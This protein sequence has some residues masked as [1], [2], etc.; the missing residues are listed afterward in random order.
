MMSLQQEEVEVPLQFKS[1][2]SSFDRFYVKL[3]DDYNLLKFFQLYEFI[4]LLTNLRIEGQVETDKAYLHELDKARFSVFVDNKILKNH[5]IYEFTAENEE[6]SNIFKDY[7]LELFDSLIKCSVD[8]YKTKNPG[9]KVK[10]GQISTVKKL[11]LIS[12]GLLYCYSNNKSKVNFLFN[13]F[14]SE[15]GN[16]VLNEDLEDFLFFL[17]IIPASCSLWVIKNLGDKYE[18]IGP[19]SESDFEN[20]RNNFEVKDVL[21]LRGIFIRDFFKG[22]TRLTREAFD[23]RFE[24]ADG[25]FGWIFNTNG[26]RRFLEVN[27]DN[28]PQPQA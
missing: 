26:I 24:I 6:R 2:T 13:L 22:E 15:D 20:T 10:K 14:L 1:Y 23:K 7:M 4:L 18:K 17:F 25:D 28:D 21:R 19:I 27:N 12:L 16:F 5:L 3:E 8:L 11:T 9:K